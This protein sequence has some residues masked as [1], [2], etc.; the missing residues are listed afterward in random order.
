MPGISELMGGMASGKMAGS[1]EHKPMGGEHKPPMGG[2]GVPEH[3]AAMHKEM[4]GKH[5]HGHS[6]GF[7]HT[8]HHVK[9]DGKVEGPQ[10]HESAEAMAD[11][12]KGV[13]GDGEESGGGS[14]YSGGGSNSL[15]D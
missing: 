7:S 14:G 1:G 10:E 8:S 3:M 9:E 12:M 11:H 2:G 6:D 15:M 4:G 5:F 13:M